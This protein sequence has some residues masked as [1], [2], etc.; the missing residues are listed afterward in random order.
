MTAGFEGFRRAAGV[1][2]AAAVALP[3]MIITEAGVHPSVASLV[4]VAPE[5]PTPARITPLSPRPTRRHRHR[6]DW[7]GPTAMRN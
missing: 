7:S 4:Y 6:P 2:M 3:G 5:R 1:L